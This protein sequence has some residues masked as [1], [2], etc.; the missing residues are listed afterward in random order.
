MA[1][2]SI[3]LTSDCYLTTN[4][5]ISHNIFF[6]L[7][8]LSQVFQVLC[9]MASLAR[10]QGSIAVDV[11]SDRL[12]ISPVVAQSRCM[13]LRVGSLY[14]LAVCSMMAGHSP[15]PDWG[16]S[17]SVV[18]IR[19]LHFLKGSLRLSSVGPLRHGFL[20]GS[21]FPEWLSHHLCHIVQR[22]QVIVG[23]TSIFLSSPYYMLNP[24]QMKWGHL[25]H[26]R[27]Y[28]S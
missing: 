2:I 8:C 18:H 11:L 22:E 6:S 24:I 17:P 16:S 23:H 7:R 20:T 19:A 28:P 9:F 25:G 3:I 12:S 13:C 21:L 4:L 14:F 15:F 1:Y 10:G 26:L 5:T 27:E